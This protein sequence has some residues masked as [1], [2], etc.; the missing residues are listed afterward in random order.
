MTDAV[1]AVG[2]Q[3]DTSAE[4]HAPLLSAAGV[5]APVSEA[6]LGSPH[7][8][9]RFLFC[10]SVNAA[11]SETCGPAGACSARSAPSQTG[12]ERCQSRVR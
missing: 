11:G 9:F 8:L 7:C 1:W 6:N 4:R 10:L 3:I 12:A 2:K 5:G